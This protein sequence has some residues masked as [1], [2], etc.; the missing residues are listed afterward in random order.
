M[1]NIGDLEASHVICK[2]FYKGNVGDIQCSSH[3]IEPS[4]SLVINVSNI[5]GA[6]NTPPQGGQA[7]EE[8][9]YGFSVNDVTMIMEK[10]DDLSLG[11]TVSCSKYGVL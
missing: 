9:L 1:E 10:Q 5:V 2:I 8:S 4:H 3:S 11:C 6:A 7:G